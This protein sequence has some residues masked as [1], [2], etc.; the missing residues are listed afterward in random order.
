VIQEELPKFLDTGSSPRLAIYN[1]GT[2]VLE[3]DRL[4]RLA[5]SAEGVM[6]RDRMVISALAERQIP[7]VVVTSGGYNAD[8]YKLIA[9][10]A[11]ALLNI[12]SGRRQPI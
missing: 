8:S 4:G 7:S 5:V 2:D 10:M 3:G 12:A 6:K 9:E 1:A 11:V